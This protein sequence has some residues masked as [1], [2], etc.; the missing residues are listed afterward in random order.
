MWVLR[1]ENDKFESHINKFFVKS[2]KVIETGEE[3]CILGDGMRD[4]WEH[5]PSGQQEGE[6][7]ADR[8]QEDK[9]KSWWGLKSQAIEVEKCGRSG[10]VWHRKQLL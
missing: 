9:R 3:H 5:Q 10:Q 6:L 1:Q 8:K 2:R 7:W 4:D